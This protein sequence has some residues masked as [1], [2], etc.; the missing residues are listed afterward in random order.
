MNYPVTAS[1]G[2][3]TSRAAQIQR[4]A[5]VA[6]G[7]CVS[8]KK[9]IAFRDGFIASFKGAILLVAG[10]ACFGQQDVTMI[11]RSEGVEVRLETK[12]SILVTSSIPRDIPVPFSRR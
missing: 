6:R 10:D 1:A 7:V 3:G 5:A 4:L 12:R 9:E 8:C 11:R 2:D